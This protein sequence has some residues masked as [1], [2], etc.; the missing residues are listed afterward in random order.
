MVILMKNRLCFHRLQTLERCS[1]CKN[2]CNFHWF[3]LCQAIKSMFEHHFETRTGGRT[4]SFPTA[5]LS[6]EA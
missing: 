6:V 1:P 4:G 5:G 2:D 3:G